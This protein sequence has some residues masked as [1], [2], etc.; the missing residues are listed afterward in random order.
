MERKENIRNIGILAHIDHGKTTL[1]DSLLAGAGLLP[2]KIAGQARALDYLDEEQKRGITIK[3]ANI[4]LLHGRS[5]CPYVINLVDTP[6]HVDFTG[7]VTRALRAIDGAVIVVDAVEEV[8]AQTETVTR[9]ALGERVRP[10]LF[11]NKVDRL[12]KEMKLKAAGI[13]RKIIR[14]IK[15]FNSLIEIYG[16][17]EFR[18]NWR[19][20]PQKSTVAFGS[21]LHRWGFTLETAQNAGIKI[22]DI[23]EAYERGEHQSLE[24]IIPLHKAILDMVIEK[25]PSPV[26]AQKYRLPKIWRGDL[27]SE[28]GRSMLNCSHEGP[29]VLCITSAQL[30]NGSGIVASG[31]LFSG[32]IH[33]GDQ[34]YLLGTGKVHS[35]KQVS[36][37]MGPYREIVD[38][39]SAG[40]I[41]ALSG[42]ETVRAGETVVN[43]SYK[44][45]MVPF[46]RIKYISEPVM[47]V[48]VE[49]K[50]PEDL[51]RLI[52]A[53][54]RLTLEDPNLYAAINK[55]TGEYLLSGL[56]ELHLEVAV[57]FLRVYGGGIEI[58]AS[59]PM[60]V[61]R[62][63]ITAKGITA[64]AKSPNRH[65]VFQVQ[66]EPLEEKVLDLMEKSEITEAM[67]LAQIAEVLLKKAEWPREEAGKVLAVDTHKNILLNLKEDI[68]N[69]HGELDAIVRGFHWACRAGPL[70]EEPIRGLKV[71]LVDAQFHENL[72]NRGPAQV[73]P[74]IRRG[75]FSSFLTAKPVILEPFYKIEISAPTSLIGECFNILARKRGRILSSEHKNALTMII[76]YI[77]VAEI[78]GLSDEMRSATSGRVFWQSVF[79]HWERLPENIAAEVIRKIRERK[80]LPLEIPKPAHFMDKS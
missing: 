78:F 21:A 14:I 41:A 34:V 25:V 39:V 70:C 8:M 77:P 49:P 56:G 10:L 31:R 63:S 55:E 33:E 5:G 35:V 72:A 74:A 52:E 59:K 37:Y 11:I 26:E 4:S 44:D 58:A 79:S 61:Y 76:G 2:P 19:V 30:E 75:I 57:K 7:K 16:E 65:N 32:S 48:A 67:S 6:G 27:N 45:I 1:A 24:E 23:I 17:P 38:K 69:F 42:L 62:E 43:P 68:Q 40:N 47:T 3:T 60:A 36:I 64:V 22:S 28:I 9:Q 20:D 73:M 13:Q 53:V 29:T 71:K 12:I 18:V 46:E 51:P 66:V 50:N 80:G 54:S 15:D